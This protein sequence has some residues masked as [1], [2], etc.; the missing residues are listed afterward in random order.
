MR[1]R[2]IQL[3]LY[4]AKASEQGV[5]LYKGNR[6]STPIELMGVQSV[7]EEFEYNP[8]FIVKDE[9]G[10]I[11]EIWFPDDEELE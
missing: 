5:L 11:K 7:R 4:L 3:Y 6:L 10:A 8:E 2:S 9:E 1:E